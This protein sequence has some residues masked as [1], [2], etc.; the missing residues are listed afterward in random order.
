M[1]GKAHVAVPYSRCSAGLPL[2]SDWKKSNHVRID[3]SH[4]MPTRDHD[5]CSLLLHG[6]ETPVCQYIR[7]REKSLRDI[8]RF[9]TVIC[10][11]IVSHFPR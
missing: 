5:V 8:P 9:V 4:A 3:M 11:S 2:F 7:E 1:W 6:V 10:D